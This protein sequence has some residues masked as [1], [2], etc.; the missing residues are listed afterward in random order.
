MDRQM[1]GRM[2]RLDGWMNGRTDGW[3]NGWMDGS[4]NRLGG[5]MDGQM[6]RWMERWRYM[7]IQRLKGAPPPLSHKYPAS[8]VWVQG[9]E[10]WLPTA[11]WAGTG[12][13]PAVPRSSQ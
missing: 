10:A 7:D 13:R 3:M 9:K 8:G 6:A 5:W 1:D 4:M 12:K 11:F 2:K